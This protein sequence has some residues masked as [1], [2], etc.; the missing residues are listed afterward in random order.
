[1][2]FRLEQGSEINKKWYINL[3]FVKIVITMVARGTLRNCLCSSK[4]YILNKPST[5]KQIIGLDVS[6]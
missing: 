4:E 6:C 2:L 5:N 3:F 1:M